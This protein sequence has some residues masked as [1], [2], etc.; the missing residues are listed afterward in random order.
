MQFDSNLLDLSLEYREAWEA[1][2]VLLVKSDE[3][4]TPTTSE[5]SSSDLEDEDP[6]DQ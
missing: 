1:S 4:H 2:H 6:T 5:D 3:Y